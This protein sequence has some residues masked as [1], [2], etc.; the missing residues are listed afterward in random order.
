MCLLIV[1]HYGWFQ[2]TLTFTV[3]IP[4]IGGWCISVSLFTFHFSFHPV[5][6]KSPLTTVFLS[7]DFI[8]SFLP[9]PLGIS[10]WF[11]L[12]VPQQIKVLVSKSSYSS[13][14]HKKLSMMSLCQAF[15]T[16]AISSV[17]TACVVVSV[18]VTS[19]LSLPKYVVTL[20]YIP[21][22]VCRFSSQTICVYF[23][24]IVWRWLSLWGAP[25]FYQLPS[26]PLDCNT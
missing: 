14:N 4:S 26:V 18:V 17:S 2:S 10:F 19:F 13:R 5:A 24:Y 8:F 21:H 6:V 25:S 12:T 11:G 7:P 22:I 1:L 20:M 16:L 15:S 23:V 9:K 3:E